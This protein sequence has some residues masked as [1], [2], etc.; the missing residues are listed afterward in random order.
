M[1]LLNLE[2]PRRIPPS[3]FVASAGE[4]ANI[5][6]LLSILA[7]KEDELRGTRF[8]APCVGGGKVS[9]RGGG[10]VYSF[11]PE[12]RD[13]EG[14]GVFE[15]IDETTAELIE[16]AGPHLIGEYL[17]GFKQIRFR[18]AYRVAGQTW[19]AYPVNEADARQRLGTR[20]PQQVYLTSE[21]AQFEQIIARWDGASCWFEETDRR[22]D[23]A[24]AVR[25]REALR[26]KTPPAHLAWKNC[27]P[28][29]RG[30]YVQAVEQR[31]RS[32]HKLRYQSD[33]QRLHEALAFGGGRL[34]SFEEQNDCWEV[35]WATSNEYSYTSIIR[36]RDLTVIDA[37]FC[38][39]EQDS[40]FDLQSL[41][42][43]AEAGDC[44]W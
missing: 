26:D 24:N 21:G 9:V 40:D 36:K 44:H 8:L 42:K 14:W 33:E 22:A 38:L 39:S 2:H 28:E 10:L 34:I 41:V 18:L 17:K 15:P 5:R 13:F 4:T 30:C 19:L 11:T 20:D 43:V 3:S 1:I 23:P 25:L 27:T 12:P 35:L 31:K 7:A 16:E 37:G 32:Q 29:M 6:R